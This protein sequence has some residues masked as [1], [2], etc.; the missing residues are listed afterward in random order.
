MSIAIGIDVA[1]AKTSGARVTIDTGKLTDRRVMDTRPSRGADALLA[2][3]TGLARGLGRDAMAIGIAVPERVDDRGHLVTAVHWDW[4]EVDFADPEAFENMPGIRLVGDLDAAAL[5][6]A[7]LGAGRDR[8]AFIYVHVGTDVS[9][10]LVTNGLSAP[11]VEGLSGA[12][13][14]AAI[15]AAAGTITPQQAVA[16]PEHRS[17]VDAAVD[18]LATEIA[19]LANS[20]GAN[21]VVVGGSLGLY[22]AYR[23]L[24]TAAVEARGT[25]ALVPAALGENAGVVGAALA[26]IRAR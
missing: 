3:V 13:T 20:T 21:A 15:A 9:A 8:E 16:K 2:D 26:A 10:T 18:A 19:S 4:R 12:A 24:L 22:D 1:V 14:G 23:A 7:R 6:E 11:A 17:I 5:A 25:I